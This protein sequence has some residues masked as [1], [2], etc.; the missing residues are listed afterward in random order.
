MLSVNDLKLFL[1]KC[2]ILL[3]REREALVFEVIGTDLCGLLF[4]KNGRMC[5]VALFTCAVFHAIH[6]EPV[7]S[8]STESFL[9][10]FRRFI[11]R[12]GRPTTVFSDNGTNLIRSSAEYNSIDFQKLREFSIS[13]KIQCN[14]NPPSAPR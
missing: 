10:A 11:A 12:R 3:D 7:T 2:L 9:L 4:L 8:L 6:V 14:F 1:L 5:W 13:K